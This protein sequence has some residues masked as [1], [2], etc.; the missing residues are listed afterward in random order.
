MEG[1]LNSALLY[2]CESWFTNNLKHVETVVLGCMKTMLGVR[3][4]TCADL[5]YL[6][7][8]TTSV[9]ADVTSRQLNFIHKVLSRADFDE[10]PL[11]GGSCAAGENPPSKPHYNGPDRACV[12]L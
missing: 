11:V 12:N 5:V 8:G 10:S 3:K 6:E 1:A 2:G 4:Q 7:T 9:K